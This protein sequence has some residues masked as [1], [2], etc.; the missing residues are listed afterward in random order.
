LRVEGENS[1]EVNG[2]NAEAARECSIRSTV[3]KSLEKKRVSA[4][5]GGRKK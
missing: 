3:A 2:I 1:K 4:N 5:C